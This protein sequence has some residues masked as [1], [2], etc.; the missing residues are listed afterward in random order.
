MADPGRALATAPPVEAPEAVPARPAVTGWTAAFSSL[1]YRD[2]ALLWGTQLGTGSGMWMEM[3]ARSWLVYEM[4][5]SGLMLGAVNVVRG[6]PQLAFGLLAG[7]VIDRWDR[8]TI[9]IAAMTANALL[10]LSI[11]VLI[12]TGTIQVWHI[13]A[14]AFLSGI[15][16]AFQMPTRQAMLPSLV[17]RAELM[18]AVALSNSAMNLTRIGGPAF[19]GLLILWGGIPGAFMAKVVVFVLAIA[20]TFFVRMPRYLEA[21]RGGILRNLLEG[22]RYVAHH[23]SLRTII[24]MTLI[25]MLFG[26]PYMTVMPIF[27]QEVLHVGPEGFGVLQSAPGVGALAAS[28][29]VGALG[30]FRR[31]GWL[32]VGGATFFGMGLVAMALSSW[33]PLTLLFLTGVG[34]GMTVYTTAAN[35]LIMLIT[36]EQFRGRVISIYQL[37]MALNAFGAILVGTVADVT[38]VQTALA[39]MGAMCAALAV[40][41]GALAPAVRRL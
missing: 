20:L 13:L 28:V 2:F 31:K 17:P 7:V 21:P 30:D 29:L 15:A 6:A 9:L 41:V 39:L 34:I 11:P 27:A 18:N 24:F 38:G 14:T 23:G 32:L 16:M 22:F 19:A 12:W 37:D 33:M 3:I 4:T 10:T 8:K 26:M 40:G 1:R 35:T 5:G 36:P 25:P